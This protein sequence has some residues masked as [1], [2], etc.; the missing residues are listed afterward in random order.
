MAEMNL[1]PWRSY[2]RAFQQKRLKSIMT[3]M[4]LFMLAVLMIVHFVISNMQHNARFRLTVLNNDLKVMR[5]HFEAASGVGS[6]NNPDLKENRRLR[7]HYRFNTL[8][9]KQFGE[10]AHIGICFTKIQHVNGS[11]RFSGKAASSSALTSFLLQWPMAERF[12]EI[13]VN[14]LERDHHGDIQFVFQT[15]NAGDISAGTLA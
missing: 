2:E 12:G 11:W 8:F 3:S 13:H 6:N 5:S 15:Q 7:D 10:M 14:S 9:F 4:T 1:L